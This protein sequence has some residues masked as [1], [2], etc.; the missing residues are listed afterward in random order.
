LTACAPLQWTRPA[1]CPQPKA[2]FATA[3]HK[4]TQQA[5]LEQQTLHIRCT[6]VECNPMG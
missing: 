4:Q 6:T 5:Q 2:H 3:A 1:A